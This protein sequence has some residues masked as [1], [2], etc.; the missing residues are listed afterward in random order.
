[1]DVKQKAKDLIRLA[2]DEGTSAAE[3]LA[4][5][6]AANALIGQYKLLSGDPVNVSASTVA[7]IIEKVTNPAF[8]KEV[9]SR[10]EK[11]VSGIER[12]MGS[13]SKVARPREKTKRRT[14]R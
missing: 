8:I 10:A 5:A 11:F 7:G 6:K 13:A 1:M 4:A 9:A 3:R 12:I 14:Y 2:C